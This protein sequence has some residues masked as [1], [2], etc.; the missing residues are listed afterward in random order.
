MSATKLVFAASWPGEPNVG[1]FPGYEEVTV[2]FKYG[3]PIDDDTLLYWHDV[4]QEFYDGSRVE[5]V[6]QKG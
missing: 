2:L 1:I 5:L 3:Q 6:E 4:I